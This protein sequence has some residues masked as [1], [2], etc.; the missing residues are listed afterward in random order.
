MGTLAFAGADAVPDIGTEDG[1]RVDESEAVRAIVGGGTGEVG[2]E[3]TRIGKKDDLE[4][5]LVGGTGC[6]VLRLVGE[7]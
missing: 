5:V 6:I 2:V 1:G 4:R 3:G 7:S